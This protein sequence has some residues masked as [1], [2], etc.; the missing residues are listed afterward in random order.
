MIVPPTVLR[1]DIFAIHE[2][3]TAQLETEPP[4]TTSNLA[5]GLLKGF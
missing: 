5:I 2:L 1:L 4:P 3:Q